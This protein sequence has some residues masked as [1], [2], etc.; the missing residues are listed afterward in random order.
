MI[1]AELATFWKAQ[2]SIQREARHQKYCKI[3]QYFLRQLV[4]LR[5]VKRRL[6]PLQS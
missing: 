2:N 5:V 4:P 1:A 6:T 3:D